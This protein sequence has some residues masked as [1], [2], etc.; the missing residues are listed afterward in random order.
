VGIL[1]TARQ[2]EAGVAGRRRGPA[3]Q[4]G[5]IGTG[6]ERPVRPLLPRRTLLRAGAGTVAVAVAAARQQAAAPAASA[7]Q[8]QVPASPAE[9]SRGLIRRWYDEVWRAR[10]P[11]AMDAL[12]APTWVGHFAT[13]ELPDPASHKRAAVGFQAAFPD[14][15]YTVGPLF[16]EGDY[17]SSLV[18]IRATHLGEFR[19][20]AATGRPITW[21]Q[22]NIHRV[23][24][25]RIAEQWAQ[26]DL[27]TVLQQLGAGC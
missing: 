4:G 5:A 25:G 10:N 20:V 13:G 2:K 22:M 19:G 11:D 16:G 26:F 15:Q 3:A 1:Q 9:A 17:V 21:V 18:T 8:A 24:G 27:L 6:G 14:A 7:A 12:Y 23:E